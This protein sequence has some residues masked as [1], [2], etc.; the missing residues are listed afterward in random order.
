MKCRIHVSISVFSPL[1][2]RTTAVN[3]CKNLN[4]K[5]YTMITWDDFEQTL[6]AKGLQVY[7]EPS[8]A[9]LKIMKK[10]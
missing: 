9:F 2:S 4:E 5:K 7:I 3:I 6:D 8:S 10:R 1:G